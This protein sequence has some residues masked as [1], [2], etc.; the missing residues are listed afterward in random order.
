MLIAKY[1]NWINAMN[2]NLKND[3]ITAFNKGA[4]VFKQYFDLMNAIND[5]HELIE[6]CK[7]NGID[8]T[9]F[10]KGISIFGAINWSKICVLLHFGDYIQLQS[11]L[12]ITLI[13][14]KNENFILLELTFCLLSSSKNKQMIN[15]VDLMNI[16]REICIFDCA[17]TMLLLL[18]YLRKSMDQS[19]NGS[20][21]KIKTS[22]CLI[23]VTFQM[24]IAIKSNKY[25]QRICQNIKNCQNVSKNDVIELY[26]YLNNSS[27]HGMNVIV[28][29]NG[30]CSI[31]ATQK[32]DYLMICGLK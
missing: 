15:C 22:L 16:I 5:R 6:E 30:F 20:L 18:T 21:L 13:L 26:K 2:D 19:V 12:M 4:F 1:F 7:V 3:I 11:P 9:I 25:K 29:E 8:H 17:Q 10:D 32:D 28:S 23:C 27:Y 31:N 14:Q 24:E